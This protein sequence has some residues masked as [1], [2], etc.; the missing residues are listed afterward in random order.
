L[1]APPVPTRP[2]H[3]SATK[4]VAYGDSITE[5]FIQGCPGNA[6]AAATRPLRL[7]T[8]FIVAP[9]PTVSPPTAYPVKLQALLAARYPDQSFSIV[10]EGTGGEDIQ[11]GAADLPRVLTADEP[12]V[13]LLQEGINTINASHA[14][15][16]PTVVEGLRAMIQEA[17]RRRIVVFV[18]TL[19]PE[20]PG[21]CRA[22]DLLDEK[23][24]VIAANVLIRT[25]VGDEGGILVDLYEAFNGQ[26]SHLLG[27]DGLHPSAAGY[28]QIAKS[29]FDAIVEHLE[30]PE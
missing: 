9:R 13:L 30:R 21:G 5:G 28:E 25:M 1:P 11:T 12:E 29:F 23:D 6:A 24:D 18:G 22:Y 17:R 16:I 15:G 27:E 8:G 4:F 3:L 10:N 20:R 14:E 7:L 2:L 26:T 19:L